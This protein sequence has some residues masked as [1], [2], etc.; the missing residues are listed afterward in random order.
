ME[1]VAPAGNMEKLRT[2]YLYGA[3]AVY[4]GIKNFS[5]RRK[6]DNFHGEEYTEIGRIKGDKKLY[7]ALNIYF[8]R[9][10][11]Y[12]LEENL[13][14]LARFPLDGFIVSDLGI[15]ALLQRRFPG[16]AL[17]LS[18]QANCINREAARVYR[19]L[20]FSRII[21]GR[22]TSLDEIAAIRAGLPGLELEC[23]IHGAM[24]L[25]YSGRCFLS[26]YMADRSANQGNCAHP[27]RWDY[28]VLEEAER[29][30]EYFPL[31]EGENFTSILSSKDLCMIDHL[32]D[33]KEAG[34][35]AVKIEGRMKSAYY[36]AI[37]TRAYRKHLDTLEPAPGRPIPGPEDLAFYREELFKVSHRE[38]S[39]GFYFGREEM[40]G[41][42]LKTYLQSH[43]FLGSLGERLPN[44]RFQ[45]DL[46]NKIIAGE[47]LEFIGPDTALIKTRDY[48]IR[49]ADTPVSEASHG[50]MYTLETPLP[51]RTGF[52]LRR[53]AHEEEQNAPPL[54]KRALP[55]PPL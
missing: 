44:R 53:P 47:E 20:G 23:F 9:E 46:K 13:D 36:T 15:I 14:Y 27:C 19:D 35:G 43:L 17:H 54:R 10:D 37:I 21:L 25:A 50:R 52:F 2:A 3:D 55:D 22:E 32:G 49:E 30:G 42:T 5:L 7:G 45:L 48:I 31:E 24:C 11:L 29:P 18:T 51:V 16:L 8:H 34:V 39:T 28:R 41:P 26:R 12:A 1:L 4:M 40:A 38:F 33:L 6:A